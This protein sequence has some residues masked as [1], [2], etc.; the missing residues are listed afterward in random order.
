MLLSDA[1]RPRGSRSVTP[2]TLGERLHAALRENEAFRILDSD[3]NLDGSDW[4][5][6]GCAVL[7]AALLR[8][9][10][11]A[12]PVAVVKDGVQHYL[13]RYDGMLLD[14]HGALNDASFW[15]EWERYYPHASRA[16]GA[17][18]VTLDR[19]DE[20]AEGEILCPTGVVDQLTAFLA[21]RLGVT[22][23]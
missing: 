6:G 23:R 11:G 22:A 16:T 7:A 20:L 3:P 9:L 21:P 8:L 14:E 4:G 2:R 13:V 1:I 18:L 10:P 17:R 19:G 5:Q 15:R 12:Q